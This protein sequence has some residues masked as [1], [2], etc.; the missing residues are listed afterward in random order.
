MAETATELLDLKINKDGRTNKIMEMES[1]T[2]D[3]ESMRKLT[4]DFLELKNRIAGLEN[5]VSE[6]SE[7]LETEKEKMSALESRLT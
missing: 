4:R 5:S 2:R 6:F 7:G 1:F 3:L